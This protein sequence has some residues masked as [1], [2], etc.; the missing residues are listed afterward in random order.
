MRLTDPRLIA[1]AAA[2]DIMTLAVVVAILIKVIQPRGKKK[3]YKVV[4]YSPYGMIVLHRNLSKAE[5]Q[6]AANEY[7][8]QR[9]MRQWSHTYEVEKANV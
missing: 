1:F 6:E 5:A 3:M 7:T 8:M 2:C 9:S 4:E